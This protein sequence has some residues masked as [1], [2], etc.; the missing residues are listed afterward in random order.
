MWWRK[1]KQPEFWD[2][3]DEALAIENW[4]DRMDALISLIVLDATEYAAWARKQPIDRW[5]K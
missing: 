4:S 5:V 3:C 1:K 2:L